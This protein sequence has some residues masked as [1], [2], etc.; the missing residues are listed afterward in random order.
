M[1]TAHAQE[2]YVRAGLGYAVPQAGQS[3]AGQEW[4]YNGTI[5]NMVN[6][7]I[8]GA[9]FSSGIQSYLGFGYMFTPHIGAQLDASIGLSNTTYSFRDNNVT[10]NY[11]GGT[12]ILSNV[13]ITTRATTPVNLM[14]SMVLQTGGDVWNIYSRMGLALPLNSKIERERSITNAPGTGST[15]TTTETWEV[16]S[17]FSLGFTAAAGVQYKVNNKMSIWGELSLLSL[18]PYIREA[19]LKAYSYNGQN[20]P[21]SQISGT[22]VYNYSKNVTLDTANYSTQ[23]SYSQPFSNVGFN[24]GVRYLLSARRKTLAKEDMDDPIRKKRF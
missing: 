21:L 16:K 2:F 17:Y 5:S 23:P 12:S 7:D 3:I 9:S 14:P 8:A 19:D 15:R 22:M 24:A 1:I 13:V 11:T 18:A 10:V 20:I 6:Y 4:P